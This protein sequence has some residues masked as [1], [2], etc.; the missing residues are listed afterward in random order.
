MPNLI[1]HASFELR[2]EWL[3][4]RFNPVLQ[5]NEWFL[6]EMLQPGVASLYLLKTSEN[7]R[8]SDVFRGY[9]KAT[10]GCDG[11]NACLY[12]LT[13]YYIQYQGTGQLDVYFCINHIYIYFLLYSNAFSKSV[14]FILPSL[15][16]LF[17]KYRRFFLCCFCLLKPEAEIIGE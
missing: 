15:Q 11:L 12:H 17:I 14:S 4:I 2:V 7:L 10:I 1:S 5:S 16:M 13:F 3:L 6:N 8:F 9:R